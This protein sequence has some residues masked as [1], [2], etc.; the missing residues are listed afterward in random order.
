MRRLALCLLLVL[1]ACGE[2]P[3]PSAGPADDPLRDLHAPF[4]NAQREVLGTEAR[5]VIHTTDKAPAVAAAEK[6]L[7]E[8]ERIE[9]VLSATR[10]DSE[11][12]R[13]C[14]A[15]H[16]TPVPVSRELYD[17]LSLALDY[18]RRTGGVY[19]PTVGVYTHLWRQ[20]Q[21]T[22][23][24]PSDEA[25]RSAR[26]RAGWQKIELHPPS[27][28]VRFAVEG[29][30]LDL[31]GFARGYAAQ[32]AW[33]TL[34][35][36][37]YDQ[38]TIRV[39]SVLVTGKPPEGQTEWRVTPDEGPP[40]QLRGGGLASS[41]PSEGEFVVAGRTYSAI[42]DARTGR[43]ITSEQVSTVVARDAAAAAVFASVLSILPISQGMPIAENTTGVEARV[44]LPD[45]SVQMTR[46]YEALQQR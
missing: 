33:A 38:S 13:L 27:R 24:A 15:D 3:A 35:M 31:G 44:R 9:A 37:G 7:D 42:I 41:L 19:D 6:A 5:V 2:A 8:I 40:L 28:S 45:H 39:G 34:G 29:M 22:G 20:A 32:A 21:S 26:A 46:G 4:I 25:M 23:K 30:Q 11:L 17:A 14:A 18:A 16:G 1:A 12:T 36:A 43:P 10:T